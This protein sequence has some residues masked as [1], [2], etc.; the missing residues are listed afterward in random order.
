M[1]YIEKFLLTLLKFQDLLQ[2]PKITVYWS[3]MKRGSIQKKYFWLHLAY[4][5]FVNKSSSPYSVTYLLQ[6]NTVM[7]ARMKRAIVSSSSSL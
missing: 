3:K 2:M 5:T 4:D 6:G 7:Q 1:Y